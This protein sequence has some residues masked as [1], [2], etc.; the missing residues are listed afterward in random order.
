MSLKIG[1]LFQMLCTNRAFTL[2]DRLPQPITP[3]HAARSRFVLCR[4]I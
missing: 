1:L 2:A 4:P 3:S